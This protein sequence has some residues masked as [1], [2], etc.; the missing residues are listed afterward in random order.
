MSLPPSFSKLG[1]LTPAEV[2]KTRRLMI[3]TEGLSNSGKTEFL[4][5]APGPKVI[6]CPDISFDSALDNPH[7]PAWRDLDDLAFDPVKLPMNGTTKQ[8]DY[9]AAFSSYRARLY[10]LL[11]V[12]EIRT[13]G[14]DGDESTWELQLLAEFNKTTQIPQFYYNT[15]DAPRRAMVRRCWDSG[16]IIIAT[17]KLKDLYE[18][19][20]DETTGLVKK[21]PK[22]G[23][24]VQHKVTGEYKRQGFR[25][26]DYLW[27]L[28]IRHLYKKPELIDLSTLS[29]LERLKAIREG[30][31]KT[32]PR[33]GLRILKCKANPMLDGDE[34]WDDKCNLQGLV[35]YVYPNLDPREFGF[36]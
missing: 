11:D 21:D 30:R 16:K 17:H 9:V 3:G 24:N 25:D 4:F 32:K 12:P 5:S 29:P 35:K 18:D 23:R 26:T 20:I 34:L 33:W 6:L 15:V 22:S 10:Q 2:R 36:K 19:V 27:Q 31:V 28:Q 7:P 8:D 13:L 14:I 1:V